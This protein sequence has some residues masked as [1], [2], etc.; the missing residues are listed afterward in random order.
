MSFSNFSFPATGK[1]P[2]Q[3]TGTQGT[4]GSAFGSFATGLGGG[5]N[6]TSTGGGLFGGAGTTAGTSNAPPSIFGGGTTTGTTGG[7]TLGGGLFGTKPATGGGPFG[8]LGSAG[9]TLG[10]ITAYAN[11]STTAPNTTT[12]GSGLFGTNPNRT[13]FFSRS[14]AICLPITISPTSPCWIDHY[15][16]RGGDNM[17]F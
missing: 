7:N 10:G 12:S 1:N 6:T 9:T 2:Q 14:C 16:C 13:R 15:T 4:S 17:E 8:H 11:P 5:G 3:N